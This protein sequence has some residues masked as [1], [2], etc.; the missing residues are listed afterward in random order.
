MEAGWGW[1]SHAQSITPT[2]KSSPAGV[3]PVPRPASRAA[4][5]RSRLA[6]PSHPAR[7]SSVASLTSEATESEGVQAVAAGTSRPAQPATSVS[8]PSAGAW[9]SE[10][11]QRGHPDER[12]G[13]RHGLP[14]GAQS[15]PVGAGFPHYRPFQRDLHR[16]NPQFSAAQCHQGAWCDFRELPAPCFHHDVQRAVAD[17]RRHQSQDAVIGGHGDT[18]TRKDSHDARPL[19]PPPQEVLHRPADR[20]SSKANRHRKTSH[21]AAQ[22]GPTGIVADRH[23]AV[24]TGLCQS[25]TRQGARHLTLTGP[26]SI[27]TRS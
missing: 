23:R 10:A 3:R 15:S 1:A 5:S 21:L 17:L 12:Q 16:S 25:R 22:A 11:I 26:C 24:N 20:T 13:V 9:L 18:G 27:H 4:P 7:S 19:R 8:R 6:S 14:S 2:R